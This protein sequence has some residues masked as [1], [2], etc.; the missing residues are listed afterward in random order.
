MMHTTGKQFNP[1]ISYLKQ[2]V[3]LAYFVA[4]NFGYMDLINVP[5]FYEKIEALKKFTASDE[6]LAETIAIIS[7]SLFQY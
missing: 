3:E 7:R 4:K 5:E 6:E 2:C 1:Q